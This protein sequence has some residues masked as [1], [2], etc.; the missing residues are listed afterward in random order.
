MDYTSM[1]GLI[2][3]LGYAALF[4]V[5]C[6]GLIS[7][8]VPNEVIVMTAGA[9]SASGTLLPVPAFLCTFLGVVSGLSFGYTMGR[10]Y[11]RPLL[12]RLQ[13]K[14][15]MGKAL[16]FAEKLLSKYGKFALCASYFFPLVRHVMPY[17]AGMNQMNFKLFAVFSYGTGLAWT[18]IYF[19]LGRLMGNQ[20]QEAGYAIYYYGMRA[21]GLLAAAAAVVLLVR[22]IARA[23]NDHKRTLGQ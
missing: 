18:L 11:G 3:H 19:L 21:L 14:E 17:L 5:L 7:I 12:N 8:P 23:R 4:F 15:R 20:V 2:Q 22:W 10:K 9:V 13:K 6:L 1:L 16:H